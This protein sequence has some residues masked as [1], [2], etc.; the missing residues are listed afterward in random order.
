MQLPGIEE[1]EYL[2]H[3]KS[4]EDKSEMT[5]IVMSFFIDKDVIL[6][7]VDL[8]E[9]AAADSSTHHTIQ[10]LEFSIAIIWICAICH[11]IMV[12]YI[13]RNDSFTHKDQDQHYS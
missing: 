2:H 3:Y 4:I 12:I 13:L 7:T 11:K 6:G 1:V 10:P 5:W 9:S 8:E